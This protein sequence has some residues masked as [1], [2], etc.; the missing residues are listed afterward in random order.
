MSSMVYATHATCW[1]GT[2]IYT[3]MSTVTV[4]LFLPAIFLLLPPL[5]SWL[6]PL[7]FVLQEGVPYPGVLHSF[8]AIHLSMTVIAPAVPLFLYWFQLYLI[9][10]L[11][12]LSA[13]P[14]KIGRA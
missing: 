11:S 14:G 1:Q 10:Y 9:Q 4:Q 2:P 13:D 8:C 6:P 12:F 5:C 3:W 7:L